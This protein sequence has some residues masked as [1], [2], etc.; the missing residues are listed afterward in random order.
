MKNLF[1]LTLFILAGI[2]LFSQQIKKIGT[3]SFKNYTP[4][5]YNSAE[6]VWCAFQDNRGIMYFGNSSGLLEF[7]GKTWRFMQLPNK[8]VVRSICEEAKNRIYVG[9]VNEFGFLEADSS[10]FLK[11]HSLLDKIPENERATGDVWNIYNI[12]KKIIFQ[13]FTKIIIFENE[14]VKI[15][16]PKTRFQRSFLVNGKMYIMEFKDRKDI[17]FC[18]INLE[19]NMMQFS[20]AHNSVWIF[21][22][23]EL[24]ELPADHMPIG[25]YQKERPF[26]N[27]DFQLQTDDVLYLFSDGYVSQFGGSKGEKIK[28]HRFRELLKQIHTNPL[29]DQKS[30]L[31]KHFDEWKGQREQVDDVLVMGVKIN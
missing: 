17:A 10:G 24:T 16:F 23:S 6:Q 25:I 8:S 15:I 20:G 31:E 9:G 19:T 3:P 2:S 22:N 26:T 12:D 14:K 21:R 30:Q 27:H 1:F 7:D 5:D 4:Q 18:A 11:F 28:T 29:P 13:T